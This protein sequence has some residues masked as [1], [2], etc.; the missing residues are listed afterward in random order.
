MKRHLYIC[1]ALLVLPGLINGQDLLNKIK[2]KAAEKAAEVIGVKPPASTPAG[3][4]PGSTPNDSG[5]P[6]NKT[7]GGL[8]STPP[9]VRANLGDA[10]TAWQGKKYSEARYSVQQAMLGVEMEIGTKI[11]K[12]LPVTISGLKRDESQDRVTSNGYG[13]A[14]LTIER[15]YSGASEKRLDLTVANNAVWMNAVNLYLSGGGYAQNTGGQ[16]NMKQTKVKGY[17]AVIEYDEDSGYKLSVP[18]GQTSLLVLEAVNFS[19]E[20]E[21]MTAA[22]VIDLDGIKK[23]LGEQ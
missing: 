6:A 12:S 11:L 22:N 10:T 19:T 3:G 9:D 16:Q 7:G 8:V 18:I 13:W 20:Q 2:K 23:M 15:D 1:A 5:K 21:V 14:G 17:R 4:N